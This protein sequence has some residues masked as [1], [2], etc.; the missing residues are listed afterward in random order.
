MI[1]SPYD[2]C[3]CIGRRKHSWLVELKGAGDIP[4]AFSQ[5]AYIRHERKEYQEIIQSFR[6]D[7]RGVLKERAVIITNGS[8]PKPA[9]ERL[10]KE[11]NIRVWAIIH[12]EATLKVPDLRKT[13]RSSG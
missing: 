13:L 2:H 8:L 10:E 7:G 4:R 1:Q 9:Q 12:S 3:R 6:E 5:L 11:Y